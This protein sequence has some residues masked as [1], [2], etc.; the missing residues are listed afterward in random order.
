M[1]SIVIPAYNEEKRLP[2]TLVE[3][4]SYLH[5]QPYTSELLVVD[6]GSRDGTAEVVRQFEK[7]SNI[8]CLLR[9]ETNQGKGA[10]VRRG[11]LHSRG[12]YVLFMDADLATSLD[13]VALLL[14]ELTSGSADLVIGSRKAATSQVTQSLPRQILS[15]GFSWSRK[16]L[17]NL[18]F[19]DTQ[20][21]FKGFRGAV[22]RA[23]FG[24]SRL[25]GWSFDV[26]VLMIAERQGW[27][28]K[29]I[30]VEWRDVDGSKVSA[31]T[32]VKMLLDLVRL[33]RDFR[34]RRH[35]RLPTALALSVRSPS[36]EPE[37]RF[38]SNLS[39]GG[40][41]V[42]MENPPAVGTPMNVSI[43][44]PS[45]DVLSLDAHVA[46]SSAAARGVGLEF[47]QLGSEQRDAILQLLK[48]LESH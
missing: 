3:T 7:E 35:Q 20:C 4:L 29:E 38:A 33:R 26:E 37:L 17:T 16:L 10:S 21:G 2:R 9:G 39:S 28:A 46:H 45:G 43:A 27:R 44:L 19:E 13:A 48:R 47:V 32:P 5:A 6:D 41:F 25:N 11:V 36:G 8:V 23:I 12:D 31:F 15:F 34:S 18:R 1:L 40:V 30:P 22:A 42:V 24:E 14:N